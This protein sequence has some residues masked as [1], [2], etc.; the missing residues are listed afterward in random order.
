INELCPVMTEEPV[1]PEVTTTYKGDTIGFCCKRC[2]QKFEDDPERYAP[3]LAGLQV[4]EGGEA[5]PIDVEDTPASVASSPPP[6]SDRQEHE[7]SEPAGV[8]V[9][10]QGGTSDE[11]GHG[12]ADEHGDH[13]HGAKTEAEHE[14]HEHEHAAGGSGLGRLMAWLGRFHP[15]MVNFPIA[16]LVGAAV[17]E[18]LRMATKRQFFAGAGR[19]CLW[20]A[21][22][23]A[24]AAGVLGWFF[25]GFHLTDGRWIMTTHRWLGTA[26]VVWAVLT[27]IVGERSYRAADSSKIL[28]YRVLLFV[29]AIAVLTTGFFGGAMIYGINHY[30]W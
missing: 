8:P 2:R 18:L 22:L 27:L 10:R 26:T 1:D 7:R 23:T 16:M 24:A 29:G 25:A 17:A 4:H 20:F 11:P 9:T 30:A 5:G 12:H 21:G 14:K 19:F 15:P 6:G 28:V 13:E 3:R